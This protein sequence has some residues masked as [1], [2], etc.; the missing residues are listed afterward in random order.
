MTHHTT[1]DGFK[2][3]HKKATTVT[4]INGYETLLDKKI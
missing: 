2:N 4:N 1:L 3:S